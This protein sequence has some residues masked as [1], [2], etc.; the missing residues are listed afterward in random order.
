[1]RAAVRVRQRHDVD[2]VALPRP[3]GPVELVRADLDEP[4]GVAVVG[5]VDGRDAVP[6][7]RR[8]RQ[9]QGELVR[10]AA[11]VD[12]EADLEVVRQQRGQ[13]LRVAQD[14]LVEVA[15]VRV[16]DAHLGGAGLDDPR[17]GVADVGDVVHA[18]EVGPAVG[19]VEVR[20][21]AADDVERRPVADRERRPEEPAAGREEVVGGGHRPVGDA[22]GRGGR[23]DGG[24]P[25]EQR[26]GGRLGDREVRIVGVE[27]R[28]VGAQGDAGRQAQRDE[29][30]EDRR[31]RRR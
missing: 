23:V 1:M 26:P 14:Q 21:L 15:R 24:Q 13:P 18:V 3:A 11:A 2:V 7:R 27:P 12:E 31:A 6:S 19:V 28:L 16:E 30:G 22:G 8:S 9:P 29:L 10:L 25:L 5:D 4:L 20:A 17:M